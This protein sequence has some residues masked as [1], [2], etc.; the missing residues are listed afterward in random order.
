MVVFLHAQGQARPT[1]QHMYSSI[2]VR[3]TKINA[4]VI[5]VL[6]VVRR[7]VSSLEEEEEKDEF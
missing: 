2:L 4:V 3:V 1:K 5:I 7:V 6:A